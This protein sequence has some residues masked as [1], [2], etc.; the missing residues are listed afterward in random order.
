MNRYHDQVKSYKEHHLIGAGF[1]VQRLSP[2]SSRWEH[3]SIQTGMVEAEL[4]V[5]TL[6]LKASSRILAS[7]QLG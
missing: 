2:L 7:R 5:L 1:Q 4:R 3:A 6:H